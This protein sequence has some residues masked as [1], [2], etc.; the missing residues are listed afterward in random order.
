[1]NLRVDTGPDSQDMHGQ[2]GGPIVSL[3][4]CQILILDEADRMLDMGEAR[5]FIIFTTRVR[6]HAQYGDST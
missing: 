2:G 4:H 3:A 5:R 1:V 6:S